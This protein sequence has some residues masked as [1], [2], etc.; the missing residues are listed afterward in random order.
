MSEFTENLKQRTMELKEE[1]WSNYTKE[2][3]ISWLQYGFTSMESYINIIERKELIIDNYFIEIP[4]DI[5]F[6]NHKIRV[7]D[8]EKHEIKNHNYKIFEN[9][10]EWYMKKCLVFKQEYIV[11]LFTE[12]LRSLSSDISYECEKNLSINC[13]VRDKLIDKI[14]YTIN[15]IGGIDE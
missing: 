1:N 6:K 12:C 10:S 9:P 3:L 15:N 11:F 8:L 13:D 14:Y 7:F 2:E 5:R 4:Y